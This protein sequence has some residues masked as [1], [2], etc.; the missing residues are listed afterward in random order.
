[1]WGGR[2]GK[3]LGK[4]NGGNGGRM[5]REEGLSGGQETESS[6]VE[7]GQST[8]VAWEDSLLWENRTRRNKTFAVVS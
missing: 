1:M 5:K 3:R 2:V 6:A 7:R 4:K 8:A